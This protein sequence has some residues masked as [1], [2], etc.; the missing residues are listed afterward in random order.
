LRSGFFQRDGHRLLKGKSRRLGRRFRP[1]YRQQRHD[2]QDAQSESVATF[3]LCTPTARA[4]FIHAVLSST[5]SYG[6]EAGAL[7]PSLPPSSIY[8]RKDEWLPDD[9]RIDFVAG[10]DVMNPPP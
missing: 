3:Q 8:L 1:N 2:G 7:A 6:M 5:I 10:N 4:G 9:R